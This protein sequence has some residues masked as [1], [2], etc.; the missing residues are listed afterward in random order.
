MRFRLSF[1]SWSSCQRGK[2][3]YV[4]KVPSRPQP[5]Q[6]LRTLAMGGTLLGALLGP[7][8]A[9]SP[10]SSAN[11]A[12]DLTV[13]ARAFQV[14]A[15]ESGPVNYYRVV[16]DASGDFV[17]GAYEPGLKTTVVG[18]QLPEAERRNVKTL[19]WR[20][21]AVTLPEGGDGCTKGKRDSAATLYVS[22]K[23]GM[24]WFVIKY[25]WTATGQK[26][27][28]CDTKRNPFVAQDT[29][30]LETGE[31]L[32]W[33]MESIDLAQEFRK[34]FAGGD[35]TAEVPELQGIGLMTDGDDT[36]STS[37]GDYAGFTFTR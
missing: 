7:A 14:I 27:A 33:R 23:R 2:P 35:E 36:R 12:S 3:P 30:V 34:H 24:R 6:A 26:G 20:W 28:T 10:A 4:P 29:T 15:R 11:A 31:P 37:V 16:S 32:A 13:P 22:W 5:I 8:L 9:A 19:R 25:V 18:W 17:R 21:R 1:A